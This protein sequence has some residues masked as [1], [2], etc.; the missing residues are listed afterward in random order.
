[1]LKQPDNQKPLK[2]IPHAFPADAIQPHSAHTGSLPN[3]QGAIRVFKSA[4]MHVLRHAKVHSRGERGG[5]RYPQGTISGKSTF[6]NRAATE[7]SSSKSIFSVLR[8]QP[9]RRAIAFLCRIDAEPNLANLRLS[10][11]EWAEFR[12]VA[13]PFNHLS[14]CR[15]VDRDSLPG[16]VFEDSII[17]RRRAT[18]VVLRRKSVNGNH[19][20]QRCDGAPL[21]RNLGA[22]RS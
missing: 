9:L 20:V 15:A 13:P 22:P 19:H 11:P 4:E 5:L 17:G 10:G 7:A 18:L 14:R 16:D 8:V 2:G 1:M 21:L 12:K 3:W 6:G